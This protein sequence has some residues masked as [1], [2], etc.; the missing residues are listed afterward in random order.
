M[1]EQLLDN[2]PAV[3]DRPE[4]KEDSFM[5]ALSEFAVQRWNEAILKAT[6]PRGGNCTKK[7]KG[8]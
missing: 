2:T 5:K 3:E 7:E 8:C 6:G 4:D 1:S